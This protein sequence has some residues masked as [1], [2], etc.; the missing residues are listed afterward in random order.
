MTGYRTDD[1]ITS[2]SIHYTKLYDILAP[3]CDRRFSHG[4]E[5]PAL[6]PQETDEELEVYRIGSGQYDFLMVLYHKDG[7]SQENLARM[8]KVSKATSTRAIQN[9]EKEGYVYRQR[10]KDDLRAYKVYLTEKGK[11]M[12]G[13]I[14][15]KL[16]SVIT[17]YSIH[18]TKLYE[19]AST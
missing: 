1:V 8:L 14:F 10:D 9:L 16:V 5:G 2:Y 15:E 6:A 12:R 19:P 3:A 11:E 17:S 18:Y 7:I 13:V 4:L